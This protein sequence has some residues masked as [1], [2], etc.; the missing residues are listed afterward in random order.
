MHTL[1]FLTALIALV[2]FATGTGHALY[3]KNAKLALSDRWI[4]AFLPF[5]TLFAFARVVVDWLNSPMNLWDGERLAMT[6]ARLAGDVVFY[7]PT[8]GPVTSWMYGPASLLAFFPATFFPTPT[9]AILVGTLLGQI[10]YLAPVFY[11]CFKTRGEKNESSLFSFAIFVAFLL[12]SYQSSVLG[13]GYQGLFADVVGFVFA[14]F[15]CLLWPREKKVKIS[16]YLWPSVLV[17]LAVWSKQTF[18]PLVFAL[19]L[20]AFLQKGK[21]EGI[22]NTLVAVAT[23]FVISLFFCAFFPADGLWKKLIVYP[24]TIPWRRSLFGGGMLSLH[25][26]FI[27]R[28]KSLMEVAEELFVQ[29]SF[30]LA[31]LLFFYLSFWGIRPK[32]SKKKLLANDSFLFLWVA[33]FLVP[34]ALLGRVKVGG[35]ENTPNVCLYFVGLSL[36]AL[37]AEFASH[38]WMEANAKLDQLA[39]NFIL[40]ILVV[41]PITNLPILYTS[42]QPLQDLTNN[43]HEVA[44]QYAKK[45]PGEVYFPW[46]TLPSVMVDKKLYHSYYGVM[47][48]V[49]VGNEL[50]PE[51]FRKHLPE[52]LKQVAFMS[53]YDT[54]SLL[55]YLPEFTEKVEVPELP[56]WTVLQKKQT[57]P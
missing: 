48:Q 30:L 36:V 51:H 31:P 46:S 33:L 43:P 12:F 26:T 56:G 41:F 18:L 7:G 28:A 39:K 8:D 47:D 55:K 16:D 19:P 11:L 54:S 42:I 3:R 23:L 24:A 4:T 27:E 21:K 2:G 44:Y 20:Y 25:P 17:A 1:I 34:T 32:G 37:I 53:N 9:L 6:Y 57:N 50:T 35:G 10:F 5:A 40:V 14:G 13:S 22:Q 49:L 29:A 15:A 45:H 38:L 52:N